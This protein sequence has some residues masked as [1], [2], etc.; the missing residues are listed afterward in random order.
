MKHDNNA[1]FEKGLK[2]HHYANTAYPLDGRKVWRDF[3]VRDNV[4]LAVEKQWSDVKELGLY[5]HI[6]FC[7]KR[8]LYCE[9]AVLSGDESDLKEEYLKL[10][11][12]E[13]AFYNRIM[14]GKSA[15][16]LD[17]GGGTPAIM[18]VTSLEKIVSAALDAYRKTPDFGMSIETTPILANDLERMKAIRNIG[19]KRIS[20]GV[21]TIN[22]K[23]LEEVGRIDSSLEIVKRARDTIREAGFERFNIDLMYGFPH[24]SLESFASTVK[25][26]VSLDPEYITLYRNRFKGTKLEDQAKFVAL[27]QVNEFYQAA[28][29]ILVGSGYSANNGK[30]TFSR[31]LNDPGTSAYLTSRVI[32][33][34]PYLGM[35]LGSQSMGDSSIYYNEGAASKKLGG[36]RQLVSEGHFPV[37]DIYIL[38]KDEI[39][40]KMISVSFY[41][42]YINKACFEKKFG[43][44]LED[45]FADELDF[46]LKHDLME[47]SG[48]LFA[49]TNKGKEVV[50]GIIPLFYSERSKDNLLAK[51]VPNV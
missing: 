4:D 17:I 49:L 43:F 26:V 25:F 46:L 38:P 37:Q 31:V 16:G 9:Y 35:G 24:E 39:M 1:V 10:L 51:V 34:T 15:V 29:N 18:P 40:A 3:K 22:P 28:W 21:Q 32:D 27:E 33:G 19:F 48:E 2:L 13:I 8:C 50:N 7:K 14:K 36:Y 5:V 42:G 6:P 12:N 11:L 30:N 23:L 44:T 47:H 45:H 41:F 20:M